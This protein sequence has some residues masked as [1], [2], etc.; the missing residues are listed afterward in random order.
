MCTTRLS[1]AQNQI[2]HTS[3]FPSDLP[4]TCPFESDWRAAVCVVWV[5]PGDAGA[6]VSGPA[7]RDALR[8]LDVT[9]P[10]AVGDLAARLDPADPLA[11]EVA[12]AR[13]AGATGSDAAWC[14]CTPSTCRPAYLHRQRNLNLSSAQF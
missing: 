1:H 13:A 5:P 10:L 7:L 11:A 12:A 2:L 6:G 9:Q 8:R 4:A 14:A 3:Q